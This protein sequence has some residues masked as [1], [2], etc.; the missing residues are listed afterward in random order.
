MGGERQVTACPGC[1]ETTRRACG[2]FGELV[3]EAPEQDTLAI[4]TRC[5][6]LRVYTGDGWETREPTD[7]EIA[8]LRENPYVMSVIASIRLNRRKSMARWN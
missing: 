7:A 3:T 4:C 6:W 2:L 1:G 5:T 8:A